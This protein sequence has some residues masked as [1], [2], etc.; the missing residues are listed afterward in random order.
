MSPWAT[1]QGSPGSNC[2]Q[3]RQQ[4]WKTQLR[5]WRPTNHNPRDSSK[6]IVNFHAR[7]YRQSL[8]ILKQARAGSHATTRPRHGSHGYW[9]QLPLG[10]LTHGHRLPL[11]PLTHGHCPPAR[12][13]AATSNYWESPCPCARREEEDRSSRPQGSLNR[14]PQG[15]IE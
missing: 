1:P 14:R 5:H 13:N 11:G 6:I 10:P 4:Q 15:L 12:Y 9:L 3:R 7:S 2:R 8:Q